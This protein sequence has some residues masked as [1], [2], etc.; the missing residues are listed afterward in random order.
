MAE[1]KNI[2]EMA[3]IL[4]NDLFAEFLWTRTGPADTNWPCENEDQH[5]APTHPSDV[6]FYYDN[7][8][9]LSRTYINCDLKSYASASITKSKITPSIESLAR[10]ISCAEKSAEWQK[11][12]VSDQVNSEISGLLF[13]YNHDGE[14]DKQFKEL[15]REGKPKIDDI[16]KKS[17]LFV[18]GP[19]D[20]FWLNNVRYEIVQMRGKGILPARQHCR[21]Y[22]PNLVRRNNVQPEH[23]RAATLE[24]LTGPWIILFYSD[25][26]T[27]RDGFVIFYRRSGDSVP[28]FLYFIDYLMCYQV[29][30]ANTEVYLR[31]LDTA[32]NAP[33]LFDK[34]VS[35]YTEQCDNSAEILA[36]LKAIKY[37][38]INDIHTQ[39]SQIELGM[40]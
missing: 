36:R 34:A 15:L 39:F 23:A 20:I 31:T 29:L 19:E 25:P 1:T 5:K 13:V 4:S 24:M 9:S 40:D 10:S 38:Q 33:A 2:A 22:Y 6:V 32:L 27:K 37:A 35:E 17:K 14:Y 26:D 11:R 28:E 18:L 7:P 21:F 3:A 30:Q 16:P 8:Y 12:F